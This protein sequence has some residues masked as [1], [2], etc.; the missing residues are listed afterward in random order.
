VSL[1]KGDFA[2]AF[3]FNL[4][5]FNHIFDLLGRLIDLSIHLHRPVLSTFERSARSSLL[6][7]KW[8]Q[9]SA[10]TTESSG[11]QEFCEGQLR[12]VHA[13]YLLLR[14]DLYTSSR[15]SSKTGL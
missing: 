3:G 7:K 14:I 4:L 1:I 13:S 2:N 12:T 15:L 10:E 11:P 5:S 9:M 6:Q 8:L